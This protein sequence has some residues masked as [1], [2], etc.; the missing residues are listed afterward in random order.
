MMSKTT[1]ENAV[2]ISG[3]VTVKETETYTAEA[4]AT[5]A[6]I[7]Y[8]EE[9][10]TCDAQLESIQ[11]YKLQYEEAGGETI[12]LAMEQADSE[13]RERL[14]HIYNKDK[15][16]GPEAYTLHETKHWLSPPARKNASQEAAESAENKVKKKEDHKWSQSL[17]RMSRAWK[18]N[19]KATYEIARARW[20]AKMKL[21]QKRQFESV[22]KTWGHPSLH[23]AV[24]GFEAWKKKWNLQGDSWRPAY[25]RWKSKAKQHG[26]KKLAKEFRAKQKINFE[27]AY[28]AWRAAWRPAS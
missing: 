6:L 18:G 19:V 10:R 1:Q 12:R 27:K 17:N 11:K 24:E 13:F 28:G 7:S 21:S 15:Y 25:D 4:A 26:Y 20:S 3:V 8:R 16:R 5:K 14:A 2:R 22:K 9:E 23:Q